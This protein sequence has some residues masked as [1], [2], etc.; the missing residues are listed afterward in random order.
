MT[1]EREML[2]YIAKACGSD[3]VWFDEL[4]AFVANDTPNPTWNPL[5]DSADCAAMCARLEIS[6][7]WLE[8]E[9]RCDLWMGPEVTQPHDGTDEGK[10]KAWMLAATSLAAKLGGMK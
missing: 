9:V 5:T 10:L 7:L 2:E 3:A 4:S 6:T 8:T 1:T